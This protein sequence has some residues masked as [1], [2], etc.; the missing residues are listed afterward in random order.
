MESTIIGVFNNKVDAEGALNELKTLGV[1]DTDI[2]YVWA[3]DK[4]ETTV[5]DG[6]G[7]AVV[8][9]AGAGVTTGAVV[10]ALA[11]LAVANGILP[12]LGSLFVAGPIAAAL[13]LTGAVATT[14]AGAMTGAAAGGLVGALS[15]LGVSDTDAR[16]YEEKVRSGGIL[17][18]AR[19]GQTTGVRNVFSKYNAEEIREYKG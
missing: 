7:S 13:G 9:G 19:S 11:G 1:R 3:S 10:G 4:N 8:D 14:A 6:T 12:G 15:G 2:S 17:V 5:V 18:T 16:V